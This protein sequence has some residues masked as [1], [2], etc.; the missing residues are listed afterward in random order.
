[1]TILK[2]FESQFFVQPLVFVQ[3]VA[4]VAGIWSQWELSSYNKHTLLKFYLHFQ[5]YFIKYFKLCGEVSTKNKKKFAPLF[6]AF[7]VVSQ[8]SISISLHLW[9]KCTFNTIPLILH[10]EIALLHQLRINTNQIP[11][12][13]RSDDCQAFFQ[14]WQ[15]NNYTHPWFFFRIVNILFDHTGFP[16]LYLS[17]STIL[18]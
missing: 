3:Y 11:L 15:K 16:A 8:T 2:P 7:M 17:G 18:F 9:S 1:M 4:A 12:W 13:K 6:T 5:H 14:D 10:N